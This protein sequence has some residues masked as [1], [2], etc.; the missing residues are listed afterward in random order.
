M[1]TIVVG[2]GQLNGEV[3]DAA[4][5]KA[6][7]DSQPQAVVSLLVTWEQSFSEVEVEPDL[8]DLC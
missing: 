8:S 1:K 3:S 6:T 2:A 7:R 5:L 4:V